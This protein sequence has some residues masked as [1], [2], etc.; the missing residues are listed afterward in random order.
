VG[1][2]RGTVASFAGDRRRSPVQFD[3]GALRERVSTCSRSV[4]DAERLMRVY[5][6]W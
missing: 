3:E 6:T 2:T 1:G 5:C 4:L